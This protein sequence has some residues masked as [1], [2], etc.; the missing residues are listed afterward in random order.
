MAL[1]LC[2]SQHDNMISYE[3]LHDIHGRATPLKMMK[4]RLAI[5]LYK[6][7][8]SNQFSMDWIDLNFQHNFN[9]RNTKFLVS[10]N[11]T[12]KIG[13][14]KLVNRLSILNNKIKMDWMNLGLDS[15]K[16]KCKALLLS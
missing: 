13:A 10:S 6:I 1:K 16:I 5:Q 8:N 2:E 7:Y 9:G 15:F 3:K 14:N 4:H 12:F 11:A